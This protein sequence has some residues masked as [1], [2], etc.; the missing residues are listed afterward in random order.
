MLRVEI[1][2]KENTEKD[3][4]IREL[5]AENKKL[6][7][8]I[9][10]LRNIV[11]KDSS[12]S[13]K[14]PSSDGFKIIHNSREKTGKKPSGQKGHKG[15]FRDLYNNPTEII[16]HKQKYCDCG[17]EIQYGDK[18]SA[19]QFVDVEIKANI[20]EHRSF[21]GKCPCCKKKYENELPSHLVNPVTYGNNLKTLILMLYAEGYIALNRIQSL[22]AETT[23]SKIKLSQGTIASWIAEF[24]GKTEKE[25]TQIKK[26]LLSSAV[27][28]KDETGVHVQNNLHWLHVLSNK[29][30]TLYHAN[31]KRGLEA[32]EAMGILPLHKKTLVRDHFKPLLNLS[33]EHQECNAHILRY[34]KAEDAKGHEWAKEMIKLLVLAHRETLSDGVK[35]KLSRPRQKYY[36]QE[37][38]QILNAGITAHKLSEERH[39]RTENIKLLERM[40][41]YKSAHLLFLSRAEVPFDNNQAER[42]LRMIKTK[43]KVSGCFRGCSGAENFAKTKSV[44]STARKQSKNL[45]ETTYSLF[46]GV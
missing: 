11:D 18:F 26:E 27:L 42:D 3:V 7:L 33:C 22:I 8:E 19:K 4:K 35:K 44:L 43:T 41:E 28:H 30:A 20:A 17:H 38:T 45:F 16:E 13:S 25:I 10:H 14:P 32:D 29:N 1:L 40:Q 6:K 12:N 24:A 23:G 9:K 15:C 37:Y 21:K 36:E 46:A 5:E 34:L 2:E 39:R 31:L